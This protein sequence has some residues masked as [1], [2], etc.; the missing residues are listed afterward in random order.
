MKGKILALL[1]AAACGGLSASVANAAPPDLK[2][3]GLREGCREGRYFAGRYYQQTDGVVDWYP[4][5]GGC[6]RR[7][8]FRV[9]YEFYAVWDDGDHCLRRGVVT[10]THRFYKWRSYGVVCE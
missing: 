9:I 8:R 5:H 2:P 6:Y 7:D 3:L 4:A 10:S 1:I